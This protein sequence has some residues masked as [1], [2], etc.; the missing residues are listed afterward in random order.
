[1]FCKKKKEKKD[2][3][4]KNVLL[5]TEQTV[6][7][8]H[9]HETIAVLRPPV[10]PSLQGLLATTLPLSIRLTNLTG[11]RRCGEAETQK[12]PAAG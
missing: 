9:T 11:R 5:R 10:P 6:K 1:M 4:S 8:L 7:F 2:V 3:S 12:Q